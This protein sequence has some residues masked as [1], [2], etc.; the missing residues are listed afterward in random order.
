MF[1]NKLTLI[2]Y[3]GLFTLA[4]VQVYFSSGRATDGDRLAQLDYQ[5]NSLNIENNNLQTQIF[6]LTSITAIEKFAHENQMVPGKIANLGSIT[7]ASLI[8]KP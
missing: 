3:I 5:L 6:N 4:L 8:T 1:K 7:V 2:I